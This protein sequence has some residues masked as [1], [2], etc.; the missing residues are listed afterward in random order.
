VSKYEDNIQNLIAAASFKEPK[1][2]PVGLS[3]FGWPFARE[4]KTYRE[5]MDDP[6]A[7]AE[8]YIKGLR[9]IEFDCYTAVGMAQ[10]VKMYQAFGN[11]AMNVGEDGVVIQHNQA[12]DEYFGPEIY[13]TLISDAGR[14]TSDTNYKIRFPNLNKPKEEAYKAFLNGAREYRAFADMNS[15]IAQYVRN[16]VEACQLMMLSPVSCVS[17][18]TSIFHSI[19]GIH[20]TLLD[21]KRMPDKVYAACDAIWESQLLPMIK[22]NNLDDFCKPY[23]FSLTAYHPECFVSPEVYDRIYFRYFKETFLPYLEKGMKFFLLGEGAFLN[24]LDRF[25]ELPKG[26]MIILLD[27]DDPF[28]AYKRIGDWCTI[29]AGMNVPLLSMGTK[30]QC[31][32]YVKKCFDTFAPGGGFVFCTTSPVMSAHD[33]KEEN[34]IA[35]YE[36]A[37]MLS[38][39]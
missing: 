25:R 22:R 36:T 33:A 32:D 31:V 7:A 23:P 39:Q 1:K 18:L 12:G 27:Q 28:E 37:N 16:E 15:L 17:P 24:T 10:P 2:V 9:D 5:L 30:Q 35:A 13:D 14:F 6:Q 26:S 29:A 20:N 11:Y 38:T 19:R 3:M 4:G 34:L 8:V 21:L